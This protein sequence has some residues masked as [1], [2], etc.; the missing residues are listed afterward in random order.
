MPT[1]KSQVTT[2]YLNYTIFGRGKEFFI[3]LVAFSPV[4]INTK[5]YS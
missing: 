5:F 1:G 4:F 2:K 3:Y